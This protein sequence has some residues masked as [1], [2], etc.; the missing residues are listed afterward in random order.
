MWFIRT[1][2]R[3]LPYKILSQGR[4]FY[5]DSLKLLYK[6]V[7]YQLIAQDLINARI[8]FMDAL[9]LDKNQKKITSFYR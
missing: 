3:F 1:G 4:E 9:K 5:P 2:K 8:T 7:G 6:S